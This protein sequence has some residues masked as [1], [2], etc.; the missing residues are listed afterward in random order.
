MALVQQRSFCGLFDAARV[1]RPFGD[2]V[3]RWVPSRQ[4]LALETRQSAL[5]DERAR[6]AHAVDAVA[7]AHDAATGAKLR[8]EPNSRIL[9]DRGVE[10]VQHW[11][12][13][14]TVQGP[15]QRAERRCDAG[16]DV[17]A[18]RSHHAR[19][20]GGGIEASWSETVTQ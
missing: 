10:H 18:R 12:G 5:E 9:A 4:E 15:L 19:R 6:I 3:R 8:F 14:A 2:R 17:R 20:E 1:Q 11:A 13:R 16:H 7:H